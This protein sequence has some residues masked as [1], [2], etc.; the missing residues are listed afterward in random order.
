MG[1]ARFASIFERFS[2]YGELLVAFE[3]KTRGMTAA[4][5]VERMDRE[6]VPCGKVNTL[7]E[8]IEDPRVRHSGSLVE[9]DHPR[10]GRL[11]QARPATVFAG[12]PAPVPRPAPGL[13]EHTEQVLKSL[14]CSDAEIAT[15]RESGAIG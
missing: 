6:G 3:E 15:W 14:G 7:D 8:V 2:N 5:V 9:Y 12:E 13:G 11:R 4:D 1:E 10:A